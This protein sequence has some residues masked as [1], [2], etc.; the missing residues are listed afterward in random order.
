MTYAKNL[1]R[2]IRGKTLGGLKHFQSGSDEFH[3]T[4]KGAN[5]P[6]PPHPS[7]YPKH[8]GAK[9][10]V[11]DGYCNV[12]ACGNAAAVMFNIYTRGY[13]CRSCAAGINWQPGKILCVPVDHDL[14]HDEMNNLYDEQSRRG[15]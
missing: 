10:S 13:Y 5:P 4:R 12:T 2:R 8:E 7:K 6:I 9:G 11:F 1:S 3:A 15:W 14:T